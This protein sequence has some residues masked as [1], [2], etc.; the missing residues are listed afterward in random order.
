MLR[1]N[2]LASPLV[3]GLALVLATTSFVGADTFIFATGTNTSL[4][5]SQLINLNA[6]SHPASA[7]AE[8]HARHGPSR[9]PSVLRL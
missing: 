6:G 4:G 3:T 5:T 1:S 7:G 2:A 9:Q 8:L